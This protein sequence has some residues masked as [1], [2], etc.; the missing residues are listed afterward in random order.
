[1]HIGIDATCWHNKRGYGRHARAL[2]ST[3]V[4][5]DTRNTY[6]LF[7]D[8]PAD[9]ETL[10]SRA[11]VRLVES[12][13][14]AAEAASANGNRS[15]GDMWRMSRAMAG[16]DPD[17]LLFPT[18]YSYVPVFSRA[19]KIVMLHDTIADTFPH[20]TFATRKAHLL[21]QTKVWLGRQGADAIA[22]VSDYSRD[23]LVEHFHLDPARVFVV[24]EASDPIFRVVDA[25]YA[26][27]TLDVAGVVCSARKVV[28]V[29]GFNPHKN[30][31]MLISVFARIARRSEFADVQLVMVGEY[32]K[33][34]FH[35]YFD[36]IAIQAADKDVTDR[37]VFTGFLPD[38]ELVM[39]L[40]RATVLVLPSLMEG[41]GLPA[42]EAAACGCPVIATTASPLPQ[43]LG[44]GGLYIDPQE[45]KDLEWAL[46]RVLKSERLQREMQAAGITAAQKLSWA[47]AAQQMLD[48]FDTVVTL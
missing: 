38:D 43:L 15:I 24:S 37:V 33:E 41:F 13:S 30:L 10:P 44:K 45:P 14:P 8:S 9:N 16:A 28:Y 5:Q 31:E 29:G 25:S 27:P 2:I 3:L 47:T 35:S 36:K 19:K 1:M 22:T 39:L 20:L 12:S 32:K 21:W 42:V 7:V 17:V 23:R 40:N 26:T 34:V 6:T 11:E 46:I 48:L 4:E 18:V